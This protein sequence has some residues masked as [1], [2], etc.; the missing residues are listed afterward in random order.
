MSRFDRQRGATI[1]EL[2]I[3]I[4]IISISLTS[5]MMVIANTT[6]ASADPMIRTQA[7]SIAN[8]YL[9]EILAQ[10]WSIRPVSTWEVPNRARSAPPS[11]TSMITTA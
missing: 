1:I 3:T 2:V 7:L 6:R 8:A 9:E 4:T 5:V 11:T 10:P